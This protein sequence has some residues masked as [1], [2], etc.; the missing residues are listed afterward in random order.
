MRHERSSWTPK[1][2]RDRTILKNLQANYSSFVMSN[3]AKRSFFSSG[4]HNEGK[5]FLGESYISQGKVTVSRRRSVPD[6]LLL[7]WDCQRVRDARSGG[8]YDDEVVTLAKR[9]LV[10][11]RT[12]DE[13]L[14]YMGAVI[15]LVSFTGH[16]ELDSWWLKGPSTSLHR[17]FTLLLGEAGITDSTI[18]AKSTKH[19]DI[20]LSTN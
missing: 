17:C 16:S 5:F 15:H 2:P 14:C 8:K 11:P 18:T 12:T 20:T 10:D 19:P 3:R 9:L 6:H 13:E 7:P 1:L 4:A